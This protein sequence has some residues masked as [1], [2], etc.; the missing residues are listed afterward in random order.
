M[1]LG[2]SVDA[3]PRVLV[4]GTAPDAHV[5]GL[6]RVLDGAGYAVEVRDHAD[7]TGRLPI[8]SMEYDVVVLD[9]RSLASG[10]VPAAQLDDV[11]IGRLRI[12]ARRRMVYVDESPVRM[13]AREFTLLHHLAANP[14][15]VFSREALLRAVWGSAWRTE[16]SVTEYIRR[17]RIL[18][19]PTGI[20]E[21]IV[22]RKGFGYSFDP[23][24][25]R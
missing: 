22:T 11:E 18:L 15:V 1:S 16:G 12:D 10:P 24:A 8:E 3:R 23:S 2:D 19:A 14:D 17:L 6:M 25:V 4:L 5:S 21:C 7:A 20:G 13:S 9:P